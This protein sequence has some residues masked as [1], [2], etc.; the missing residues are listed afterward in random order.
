MYL[1]AHLASGNLWSVFNI[2]LSWLQRE[3]WTWSHGLVSVLL[4]THGPSS[5][6]L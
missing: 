5:N 6:L 2:I 1:A 4:I 3:M